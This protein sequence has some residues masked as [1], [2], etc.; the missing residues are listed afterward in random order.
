[1]NKQTVVDC[2]AIINKITKHK[3]CTYKL[4]EFV[5]RIVFDLREKLVL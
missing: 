5:M 4:L 1:M 2:N 3:M